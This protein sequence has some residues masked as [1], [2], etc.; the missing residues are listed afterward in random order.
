M[1]SRSTIPSQTEFWRTIQQKRN[2][3]VPQVFPKTHDILLF[4][5]FHIKYSHAVVTDNLFGS[6]IHIGT[7][8][9]NIV[10]VLCKN[11]F[12]CLGMQLKRKIHKIIFFTVKNCISDIETN[13]LI[14][15]KDM[16]T[17]TFSSGL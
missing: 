2:A 1:A 15:F 4:D 16:N 8:V 14:I 13:Q 9:V 6:L 3:K 5:I 10:F 7:F 11:I 12:R 17:F